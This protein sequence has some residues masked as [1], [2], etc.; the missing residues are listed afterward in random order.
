LTTL[1][2]QGTSEIATGQPEIT[3]EIMRLREQL[4]TREQV[5][6]QL[7][8]RLHALETSRPKTEF[9]IDEN[10][11]ASYQQQLGELGDAL[12][13]ERRSHA[14]RASTLQD[15][16]GRLR[17]RVQALESLRVVRAGGALRRLRRATQRLIGQ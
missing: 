12:S 1:E 11:L 13:E 15:E 4:E 14:E 17:S 5:I 7:N 3:G 2:S 9:E 8:R 16:V 6:I 10:L